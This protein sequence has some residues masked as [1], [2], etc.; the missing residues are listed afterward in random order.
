MD[1]KGITKHSQDSFY[2]NEVYVAHT[3]DKIATN[4]KDL[5]G[6][7]SKHPIFNLLIEYS[8]QNKLATSFGKDFLKFIN[9]V[10]KRLHPN[11]WQI[12]KSWV[13]YK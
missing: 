1:T 3:D 9:P 7:K 6:N 10:T 11:Y 5:Q 2:I 13:F 12:L 4:Y 8:K